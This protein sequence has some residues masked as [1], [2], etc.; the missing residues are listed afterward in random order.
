MYDIEIHNNSKVANSLPIH[1]GVTFL[2]MLQG[3]VGELVCSQ[4]F[5]S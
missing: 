4:T 5:Q 3:L 1:L 2:D